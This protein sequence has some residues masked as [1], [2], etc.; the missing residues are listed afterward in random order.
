MLDFP[1]LVLLRSVETAVGGVGSARQRP[2]PHKQFPG[3]LVRGSGE[4]WKLDLRY[5][6]TAL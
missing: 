2:S 6:D 3:A 5:I 1:S 4:S